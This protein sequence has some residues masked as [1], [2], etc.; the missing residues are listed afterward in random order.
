MK[1]S[2]FFSPIGY[3]KL[4]I[5]P[6]LL[7]F[8]PFGPYQLAI[9]YIKFN[10]LSHFSGIP[11]ETRQDSCL[12]PSRLEILKI[13]KV[14][15]CLE[16][17][18]QRTCRSCLVSTCLLLSWFVLNSFVL[19]WCL[20]LSWKN[21]KTLSLSRLTLGIVTDIT[22]Q[23]FHILIDTSTICLTSYKLDTCINL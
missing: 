12:V 18:S 9:Q 7:K 19:S 8:L 10:F 15:S 17:K 14:S 23:S 13:A 20:V 4:K 1:D 11:G 16:S 2:V 3:H 21:F 5:R 22:N 6:K